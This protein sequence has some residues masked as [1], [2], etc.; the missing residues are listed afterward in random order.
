MA[1]F[2]DVQ[3]FLNNNFVPKEL[4]I[5][6]DG[7]RVYTYMFKSPINFMRLSSDE[8]KEV[9]W[10]ENN[11]HTI[12]YSDGFIEPGEIGVILRRFPCNCVYVKGHQKKNFLKKFFFCEIIN[13]EEDCSGVDV[14][15]DKEYH[16]C[17]YHGDA[18]SICGYVNV[19]KLYRA[20]TMMLNNC[21][22][23]T[24]NYI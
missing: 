11:H 3:G 18:F 8:K 19:L 13:V 20:T 2:I 23:P 22:V 24:C 10:L 15:F 6:Y 12:Q 9:R 17:I 21:S 14:K 7:K 16:K 1:L 4:S 5:T